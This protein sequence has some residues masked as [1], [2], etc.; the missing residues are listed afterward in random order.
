MGEQATQIVAHSPIIS[1]YDFIDAPTIL[2]SWRLISE[3]VAYLG[4]TDAV[5]A[6]ELRAES[7]VVA[8]LHSGDP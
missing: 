8:S 6:S 7:I 4:I 2:P 1:G 5:S 3:Y